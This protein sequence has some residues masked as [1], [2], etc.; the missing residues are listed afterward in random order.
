M[1]MNRV[2]H[3]AVRR[4]LVR[5]EDALGK[6][7]G[8]D[9]QRAADLGRAYANLHR[10]LTHHHETEEQLIFPALSGLGVDTTV[11]GEMDKEHHAMAEALSGT[12]RVMDRYV[13][14]AAVGDAVTA[15]ESVVHTRAVVERHLEHE[16]RELEPVF[17]PHLESPEWKV[18]EKQIRSQ[19]PGQ[20]GRFFAWIQDGTGIEEQRYLASTMPAPV[21]FVL[22]RILGHAYHRDVAPVW[23][24]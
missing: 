21:R 8:T 18:V 6:I 3:A 5:L 17:M 23:R 7:S 20:A 10:E 12:A 24:A 1:S 22:S 16:E 9:R 11:L 13:G 14:T 19:P 15:K 2:I 4:D